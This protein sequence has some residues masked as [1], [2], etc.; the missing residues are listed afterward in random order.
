VLVDAGAGVD[1]LDSDAL[2][3]ESEGD[4]DDADDDDDAA[5]DDDLAAARESLR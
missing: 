1:G 3:D 2:D 4:D 5:F